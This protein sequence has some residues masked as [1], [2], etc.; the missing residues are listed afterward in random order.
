MRSRS[1]PALAAAVV[2]AG[3]APAMALSQDAQTIVDRLKTTI[4]DLKPVCSDRDKLTAAVTSA[5]IALATAKKINGDHDVARKAGTEAGY[6]LYF[7][8]PPS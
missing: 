2:L 8:C 4:P 5:T 1:I 6:Y 3:I 7:H